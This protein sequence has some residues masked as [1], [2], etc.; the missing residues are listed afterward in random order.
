[1]RYARPAMARLVSHVIVAAAAVLLLGGCYHHAFTVAGTLP[2]PEPPHRMWH[3]ALLLGLVELSD[4]VEL[5]TLCPV[6]VSRVEDE[7]SAVDVLVAIVTAAIY[8]PSTVEVWCQ[9]G[10]AS[11]PVITVPPPE[12][13]AAP[14]SGAGPGG[15][16]PANAA[17]GANAPP[18]GGV[19]PGG[20]A[21][22]LEAP[23][24]ESAP[25]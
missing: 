17:P 21:P 24:P 3:H 22:V 14:G 2:A 5:R 19:A 11:A 9:A 25:H 13:G 8:T 12:E 16:P 10:G 1:M 4:D 18:A 23:G 6:G 7:V 15:G 20:A